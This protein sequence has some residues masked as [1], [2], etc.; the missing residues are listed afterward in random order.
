MVGL[1]P[2]FI[3]LSRSYRLGKVGDSQ[4]EPAKLAENAADLPKWQ[5]L[6]NAV[7]QKIFFLSVDIQELACRI[8]I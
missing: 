8:P 3:C 2:F 1:P 5:T 4:R 7:P 6:A